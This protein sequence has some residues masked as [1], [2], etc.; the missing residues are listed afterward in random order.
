MQ[1][2]QY[3]YLNLTKR[4]KPCWIRSTAKCRH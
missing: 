1:L 2:L 4:D 3:Q